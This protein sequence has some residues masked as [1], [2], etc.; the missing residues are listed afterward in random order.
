MHKN[1]NTLNSAGRGME[2]FSN[3]IIALCFFFHSARHVCY[4]IVKVF[5]S[6]FCFSKESFAVSEAGMLVSCAR[7]AKM[8]FCKCSVYNAEGDTTVA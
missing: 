1:V 5:F 4:F 2:Y 3:V 7:L 8:W 6:R